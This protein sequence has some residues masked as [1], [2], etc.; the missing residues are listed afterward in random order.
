MAMETLPDLQELFGVQG[1]PGLGVFPSWQMPVVD[2]PQRAAERTGLDALPEE[3]LTEQLPDRP[4]TSPADASTVAIAPVE[5]A[6]AQATAEA[7]TEVEVATAEAEAQIAAEVQAAI[8]EEAGTET[9]AEGE[10][11]AEEEAAAGEAATGE[12]D[13][14]QVAPQ[15]QASAAEGAPGVPILMPEPPTE[16]S[17]AAQERVQQVQ[18]AAGGVARSQRS[19]P[20]ADASVGA[21][22]E[23]V[24]EPVE[25]AAGRAQGALVEALGEQPGPSPEIEQLCEDIRRIIRSK[26][27]PDE[28]QLVH[29]DPGN[30]AQEAG[31]QLN[32]NVQGDTTRVSNSYN[33]LDQAPQGEP[34]QQGQPQEGVPGAPP[35]PEVNAASAVPDAV[36]AE[37][38]SLE[39]DV[40]ANQARMDQAGMSSE[41]A[42]LIE[43]GP[44]AE[45]REAQGELQTT[46]ERDPAEVLAEQE[47]ALGQAN[48]DMGALQEQALAAL[49]RSR[50]STANG[51]EGQRGEMVGTEEQMRAEAGRRAQAVFQQAQT[52]VENQIR[53]LPS[54]A[55]EQWNSGV[56]VLSEQFKADLRQVERWIE[57]RHSGGWGTVVSVWDD[58][59]GYPDWVTE[60]YNRAE[61]AFGDGVCDLIR[62][63]STDVNTVVAA[64]QAIIQNADTE[65]G[66]IYESLPADLQGWAQEE[67]AR[68]QGQLN[69]L[70]QRVMVTRD[71]FNRDLAQRAS[72]AVDE[73]RAQIHALR[74]AARGLIGRVVD[75]VNAFLEDPIKFIIEGLLNLVGIPPASFWALVARIQQVISDIADDPLGFA[76]NLL[77][78]IAMGFSQ[79][80]GNIGSH[81]LQGLLDW[82][83]SGLGSVGVQIPRD[84]SLPS[85][86]TFFLQIMGITWERIRRLLA[87]HIGEENVALIEQAWQIISTLIEQGPAGI[88]EMIKEQ[89]DP[90]NILDQ[91]LQAA[92]DFL[93]EALIQAASV[94]ILGL[95]NPAGAILQAIE[96]IYRVL[97]WIFENAARIF[98]LVETVVNGMADIIAGNLGGM[99]TAVEGALVRLIAPVIDFLADYIGLGDLPDKIADVIRGMQEWVEGILDRVIG[100][101][102]EQGRR[103][104]S[105]LGLRE[106]EPEDAEG[107]DVKNRAKTQL[108]RRLRQEHTVDQ[109]ETF[110]REVYDTLKNDGLKSLTLVRAAD[111]SG[112]EIIGEASPGSTLFKGI[113]EAKGKTYR[114]AAT[115]RL[116]KPAQVSALRGLNPQVTERGGIRYQ[117]FSQA[118]FDIAPQYRNLRGNR[119]STF[120]AVLRPEDDAAARSEIEVRTWNS[121]S[122]NLPPG[123]VDNRSHG[124][125]H[126]VHF[127]ELQTRQDTTFLAQIEQIDL[128]AFSYSPCQL[129]S[130]ELR[131]LLQ[132]INQARRAADKPDASASLVWSVPYTEEEVGAPKAIETTQA[133]LNALL[134]A[135]WMLDPS[136][137]PG[138]EEFVYRPEP[139]GSA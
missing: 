109:A 12:A 95:L 43:T 122:I 70:S 44:V 3:A 49:Q 84:F 13:G 47:A 117:E 125:H 94:R 110:V 25:E 127:I 28:E 27:P 66:R 53:D 42:Q 118:E 106:D 82:L 91:V 63:I 113:H 2:S 15:G 41:P 114:L 83:F 86:I 11:P 4:Q 34:A 38:V 16:L 35:G 101:L 98:S 60:E 37:N 36:P 5:E 99:A 17:P 54:R 115:I 40:Q 119:R 121:N 116:E 133:S 93:V 55:M 107:G 48:Q 78:A 23:A 128:V 59:T 132:E 32:Q 81:L 62:R 135:G 85:I 124:E 69:G 134:Q 67:R 1:L 29:T 130:G 96:A 126:L 90:Q 10:P 24:T 76:N 46:A 136:S 50:A 103:L 52:D 87:R 105:A 30:L 9:A 6:A 51:V 22:R 92:I 112:Y 71:N 120:G 111:E 123:L 73:V 45:A 33:T 68:F 104:L 14:E 75:A 57:D 139:V 79:F 77:E 26:R 138:M 89:L 100:W 88:F 72:Q 21:A 74:E 137:L 108:E 39:A 58:F 56:N 8:P 7:A 20:S 65:I 19:M 102:A 97:K 64:C 129:C 131:S 18:G 61:A 80:F 31:G